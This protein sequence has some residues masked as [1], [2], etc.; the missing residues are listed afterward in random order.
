L[1]ACLWIWVCTIAAGLQLLSAAPALANEYLLGPGD[2]LR[3]TVFQ[4]PDLTTETRVSESGEITFPLV[5][6]VPAGGRSP[7]ALEAAIADKL[8]TGG[9]VNRPQ[10]NVVVTQFRSL[11]VSVLG[12]VNRPGRYP[13]EQSRNRLTEVLALA[14]GVTPLGGDV[15][16]VVTTENGREKRIEVDVPALVTGG[17]RNEDPVIRNGDLVYVPRYPVFYIYGE[18][19]RPGQYRIE[20]D[21]TVQQA[22]AAGG[23][24]TLRGTDR[25]IR[26][27]RRDGAGKQVVQ[28]AAGNEKLQS[29]DVV[30]VRESLF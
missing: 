27:T 8:R 22:L 14:G 5:G 7:S 16:T 6:A 4:N 28:D 20:R 24:L 19:Q 15:V 3:I 2:L 26:L 21:M 25:A 10:V 29:D 17:G 23:G 18:V 12:Q 13:L 30:Y 1:R 9:F 11:Q